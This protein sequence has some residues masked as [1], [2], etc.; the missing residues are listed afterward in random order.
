HARGPEPAFSG[1]LSLFLAT[2]ERP[3]S[4]AA[5]PHQLPQ[6]AID[7]DVVLET[8]RRRSDERVVARPRIEGFPG[9]RR[10]SRVNADLQRPIRLQAG[11][12]RCQSS[13][14]DGPRIDSSEKRVG[15]G[16]LRLDLGAAPAQQ[17]PF[18]WIETLQQRQ[19]IRFQGEYRKRLA[20]VA[21]APDPVAR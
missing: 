14:G 10:K 3:Q 9:W 11:D 7:E 5:R 21:Q 6:L 18:G 19:Q 20:R 1:R 4:Q 13:P 16:E 2:V 17:R 12:D 15:G 8:T